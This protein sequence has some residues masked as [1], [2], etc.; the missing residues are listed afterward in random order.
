[1]RFAWESWGDIRGRDPNLNTALV[2]TASTTLQGGQRAD[3]IFGLNFIVPRGPLMGNRL[4]VEGGLPVYQRLEGPQLK[5]NYFFTVSW[6][7]TF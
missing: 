3:A 1:M 2:Q 7:K 5:T 4:S 6:Q